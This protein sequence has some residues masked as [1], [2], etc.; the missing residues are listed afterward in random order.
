MSN[1]YVTRIH[2]DKSKVID[3]VEVHRLV[4]GIPIPATP[5]VWMVEEVIK[6][7]DNSNKFQTARRNQS[8]KLVSGAE[9]STYDN[10]YLR[11]CHNTSEN[12]NLENLP[13]FKE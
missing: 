8:G 12:D 7:I 3:F 13:E 2:R 5:P 11:T 4:H 9:I 6:A 10:T 1:Y